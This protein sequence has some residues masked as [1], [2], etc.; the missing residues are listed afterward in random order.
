MRLCETALKVV[1]YHVA[2]QNMFHVWTVLLLIAHESSCRQVKALPRQKQKYAPLGSKHQ[3]SSARHP[4]SSS[5]FGDTGR[6]HLQQLTV[7]LCM[8]V[9]GC[10]CRRRKP[11]SKPARQHGLPFTCLLFFDLMMVARCAHFL[12]PCCATKRLSI[13]SS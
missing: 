3:S 12:V 5:I 8:Y 7:L 1:L 4:E 10:I 2:Q 6:Q 13:S 11:A 9:Q